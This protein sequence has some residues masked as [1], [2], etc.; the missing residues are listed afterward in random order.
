MR[1]IAQVV[2]YGGTTGGSF[3]PALGVLGRAAG[4]Q[5]DRLTVIATEVSGAVWPAELRAAGVDVHL[6]RNERGVVDALRGLRPAIVHAHFTR[7][8]LPVLRAADGADV[9]W[10]VH[11]HREDDSPAARAKA[12]LKYR[13]FGRRVA[14]FVA[15]SQEIA[16]EIVAW[17]GPAR[18]VR[19]VPNGIDVDR[20]RPPSPAERLAARTALGIAPGDRVA[21]F[22]ERVPYKGG[23]TVR[24]A[25][26]RSPGVRAL[27][28][29][30]SAADRAAFGPA[31]RTIA[32]ERAADARA[33]YWAADA[34]A[35]ASDREAF[36]YVL[37]EAMACG[38][39]VAASDIAI[40]DEICGDAESVRRFPVGDATALARALEAAMD[41]RD[42]AAARLRVVG[43]FNVDGWAEQMLRLY[44]ASTC[45][46]RPFRS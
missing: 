36:G 35:F 23:A 43:R 4:R 12:L 22:F 34:L 26:A 42:R 39:P 29:G 24:A 17:S 38:L 13:L 7:Y 41:V 27:V 40:V 28:A 18:R 5:G 8:D 33:L 3:I 2:D 14:A 1:T 25:L 32:L 21:L 31:P 20:F 9:F 37:A 44:D 19:V 10:H 11:S 30:G 16:R 45:P 6:V 15:V 46:P